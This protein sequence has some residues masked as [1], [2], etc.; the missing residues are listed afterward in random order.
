MASIPSIDSIIESFPHLTIPPINGLPTYKSIAGF[1][2]LLNANAASVHSERGGGLLEHLA[3]TVSP[4]VYTT[5]SA[6]IFIPPLNPGAVPV[7]P[8]NASAAQVQ[9]LF[10]AHKENLRLWQL[11]NHVDAAL[12]QQLVNGVH[13]MYIRTLENRHTGF[14]NVTTRQLIDHLLNTTYGNLT[15]TDLATNDS[16]FRQAY[17]PSQP[18]ESLYAQIEDAID[19]ASA[20]RTPYSTEQVVANAYSLVFNTGMFPDACREWRRRPAADQTWD[21]FKTAFAEAHAN[22]CLSQ[23]TTQGAGFH[24]ANNAMDSFVTETADAFAN[25]ATATAS[26]RQF[27]ADLAE[28]NK[29]LTKQLA[30]KDAIIAPLRQ[31]QKHETKLKLKHF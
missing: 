13:Q 21:H 15:P 16:L 2:R 22:L 10:R 26:D 5:L 19:L 31:G 14:A 7:V 27:M 25:L 18:I 29:A 8:G 28:T 4:A 30:N 9:T 23:Q 1:V 11:Y 3:L 12:K 6:V 20:G 17:D 24:S